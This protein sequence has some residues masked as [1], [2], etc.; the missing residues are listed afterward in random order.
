MKTNIIMRRKPQHL[1]KHDVMY[2]Q[3]Q[4]LWHSVSTH[5]RTY[6]KRANLKK[7]KI[8]KNNQNKK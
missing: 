8:L 5:N 3:L 6:L 4:I 2:S 1:K 7:G